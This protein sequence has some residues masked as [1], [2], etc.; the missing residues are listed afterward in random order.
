MTL[1]PARPIDRLAN[2]VVLCKWQGLS[3][4]ESHG[5]VLQKTSIAGVQIPNWALVLGALIL[6]WLIYAKS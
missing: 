3:R 4:E 5:M 6:I 1:S 2:I